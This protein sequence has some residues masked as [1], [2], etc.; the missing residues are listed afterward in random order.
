MLLYFV[1]GLQMM[2]AL[3]AK[4]L[5]LGKCL[6]VIVLF[7]FHFYFTFISFF[8]YFPP[9][10]THKHIPPTPQARGHVCTRL[11]LQRG[12]VL[13]GR[14]FDINEQL[15]YAAVTKSTLSDCGIPHQ[16]LPGLKTL[17]LCHPLGLFLLP[18]SNQALF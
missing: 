3:G 10:H 13:L 7:L 16:T 11:S 5:S 15:L 14:V 1:H 8:N 18:N 4:L 17:I 2:E 12:T 6:T 9:T